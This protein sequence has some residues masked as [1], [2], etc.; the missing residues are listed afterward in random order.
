MTPMVDRA[1]IAKAMKRKNKKP[2]MSREQFIR[3]TEAGL[4]LMC[5][6]LSIFTMVLAITYV[7]SYLLP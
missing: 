2:L 3:D 5:W 4:I 1:T 6:L 7:S